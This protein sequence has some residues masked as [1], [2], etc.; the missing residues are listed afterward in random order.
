MILS[1]DKVK[2]NELDDYLA[3]G[4][5]KLKK[6]GEFYREKLKKHIISSIFD[7]G[8]GSPAWKPTSK[9]SKY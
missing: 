4:I 2:S 6:S 9:T 1:K 5:N 8:D 7:R 3:E